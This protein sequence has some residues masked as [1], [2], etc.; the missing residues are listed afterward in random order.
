M[1][2][3][4]CMMVH[5]SL[6]TTPMDSAPPALVPI[7]QHCLLPICPRPG[8]SCRQ[9]MCVTIWAEREFATAPAACNGHPPAITASTSLMLRGTSVMLSDPWAVT[10]TSSSNLTPPKPCIVD[11][12]LQIT[13]RC[14]PQAVL[15]S[16]CAELHAQRLTLGAETGA[17]CSMTAAHNR[18][19]RCIWAGTHPE[20]ADALRPQELGQLWILEGRLQ[21]ESVEVAPR[22]N[23]DHHVLLQHSAV[24]NEQLPLPN[25]SV[26]CVLH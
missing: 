18:R 2:P 22:L 17:A 26:L 19:R 25:Q 20:L 21:Q 15:R 7:Q 1:S 12:H 6:T 14:Q 10:M 5:H 4:I 24:S 13:G 16:C 11:K 8:C 3:R 9:C 23:C